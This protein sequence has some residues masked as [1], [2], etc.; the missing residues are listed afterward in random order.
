VASSLSA[1]QPPDFI[2]LKFQ[3]RFKQKQS[4]PV[5]HILSSSL[6]CKS[7]LCKQTGQHQKFGV[8]R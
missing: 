3:L 4:L 2:S 8:F 6:G 7:T 1:H 5:R